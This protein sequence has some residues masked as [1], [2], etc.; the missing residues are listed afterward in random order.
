MWVL[1]AV[2]CLLTA[3]P[4]KVGGG[5]H[6]SAEPPLNYGGKKSY[7]RPDIVT[8]N[9]GSAVTDSTDMNVG[10]VCLA[11]SRKRAI[12]S[13]LPSFFVH[14]AASD[15][16]RKV[17]RDGARSFGGELYTRYQLIMF[18]GR[19]LYQVPAYND[20]TSAGFIQRSVLIHR[21]P[22]RLV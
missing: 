18:R 7:R 10:N 6:D 17:P 16:V 13:S 12:A 3:G 11:H 8:R 19:T 15:T 21:F 20:C 9:Y 1:C 5:V 4:A 14:Q 22:Y 2:T